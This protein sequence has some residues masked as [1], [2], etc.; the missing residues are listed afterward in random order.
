MGNHDAYRRIREHARSSHVGFRLAAAALLLVVVASAST[1]RFGAESPSAAPASPALRSASAAQN[2]A[3]SS[4]L[5]V[6]KPAGVASGDVLVAAVAARLSAG[7]AFTQPA[8]WTLVRRDDCSGPQ[9]TDLAQALFYKVAGGSEPSSYTFS[10]SAPTGAAGSVLAYSGVDTA[11]PLDGSSGKYTRNTVFIHGPS[12]DASGEG[13]RLVASFAHSGTQG[14]S[15]PSGMTDRASSAVSVTPTASVT[16]ADEARASGGATGNRTARGQTAQSCNVGGMVL[17]RPNGGSNTS[18]PPSPPPPSP[19]PPSPPPPSPPPPSPPPPSPP[20]PS[21][22][23]P[24]PPPSGSQ[25]VTNT[26]WK[27]TGPVNLDLVKIT[28]NNGSLDALVLGAGCTGIIRRVEIEGPMADGIKIQ[29]NSANAAHDLLIAGGYVSCGQAAS[30]V[31]QDG[32]QGMGGRNVTF[33]NLVIDCLGGGGGNFFPAKGGSG[34]TTPT[35]IVC[36]H[37]AFGPRHPNNVQIQT[38]VISGVRNSLICRPTS[39]RDPVIV[40]SSASNPV[41]ES[42]LVVASNDSRCSQQGLRAW[43]SG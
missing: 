41:E 36:D 19:P 24:S 10:F 29:N 1:S 28:M 2:A 43:A 8:G 3:S 20:P 33:R 30:G 37:C 13:R 31:H 26:Q 42:N 22:P 14:V 40:G 16:V 5:S 17:L 27:C 7:S 32:M 18:P 4:S 23:P 11:N 35:N 15:S 12:L 9:K 6:A 21:P 34:A 39:G 25:V 38:S